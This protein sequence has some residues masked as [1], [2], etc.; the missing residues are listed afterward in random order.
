M[1]DWIKCGDKL[2]EIGEHVLIAIPV[3]GHFEIEGA[4]YKGDGQFYGAWCSTRGEGCCY[5]VTHWMK[6]MEM[7]K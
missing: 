2:P 5:K 7:P 1:S 3:C 6:S 4:K